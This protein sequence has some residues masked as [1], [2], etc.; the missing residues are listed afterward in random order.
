[1][2]RVIPIHSKCAQ[3][4][5]KDQQQWYLGSVPYS[6]HWQFVKIAQAH[7]RRGNFSKQFRSCRR[8]VPNNSLDIRAETQIAGIKFGSKRAIN[9]NNFENFKAA[10]ANRRPYTFMWPP[11]CGGDDNWKGWT[12]FRFGIQCN[13]K[14][15]PERRRNF[16]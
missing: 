11:S 3:L 14:F 7:V 13:L 10:A 5:G 1:M 4:H 6:K 15:E 16:V 12:W 2:I 8:V 9:S